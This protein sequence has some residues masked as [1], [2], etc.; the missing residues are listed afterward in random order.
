MSSK[1][2]SYIL[3]K[4]PSFLDNIGCK[5]SLDIVRYV[6]FKYG[7]DIRPDIIYERN[8]PR[9]VTKIP[10][11]A[12][13]IRDELIYFVGRN[14]TLQWYDTILKHH[15]SFYLRYSNRHCCNLN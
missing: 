11:I 1:L 10:S 14:E 4:S 15:T 13:G 7:I 8:Y 6:H 5:E 12:L 3:Y 9:E 2:I